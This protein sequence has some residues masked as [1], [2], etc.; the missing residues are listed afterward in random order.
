MGRN[1][2]G[3]QSKGL[4]L[5]TD[6]NPIHDF[7]GAHA[8]GAHVAQRRWLDWAGERDRAK[9]SPDRPARG[10]FFWAE[11]APCSFS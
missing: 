6:V 5:L 7:R 8:I 10:F 4:P 9:P 3:R 11:V 2:V 1:A